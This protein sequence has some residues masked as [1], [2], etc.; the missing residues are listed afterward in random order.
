VT[1]A[2]TS[3]GPLVAVSAQAPDGTK[4]GPAFWVPTVPLA[5]SPSQPK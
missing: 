4:P 5:G 3:S 1:A 2:I